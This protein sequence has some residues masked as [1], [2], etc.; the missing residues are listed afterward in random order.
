MW[1]KRGR[2][3]TRIM[4]RYP[5]SKTKKRVGNKINWKRVERRKK[6]KKKENIDEIIFCKLRE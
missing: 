5:N 4:G 6:K 3:N 2:K 1:K